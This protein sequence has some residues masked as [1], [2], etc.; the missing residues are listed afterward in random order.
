MRM[1]MPHASDH[2]SLI[3]F[4]VDVIGSLKVRIKRAGREFA[5]THEAEHEEP[6]IDAIVHF[7][8]PEASKCVRQE[9]R[10]HLLDDNPCSG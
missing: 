3:G 1:A 9:R 8:D 5:V 6:M 7:R 4:G 2:A 10:R